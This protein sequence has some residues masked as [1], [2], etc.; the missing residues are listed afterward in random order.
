MDDLAAVRLCAEAMGLE[1]SCVTGIRGQARS[2]EVKT[3][4]VW[5]HYDPLTDDAQAM[6]LVKR[7]NVRIDRTRGIPEKWAV[8][9]SSNFGDTVI[10]DD[11]NR[12]I[13][14]C[15]AALQSRAA[16]GG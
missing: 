9:I 2:T 12:C 15:V 1:A 6:A 8:H 10:G 13:V 14:L 16:K 3:D 7:F 11:L 5:M 4:G